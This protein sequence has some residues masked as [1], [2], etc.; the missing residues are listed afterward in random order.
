MIASDLISH[1]IFPLKKNDSVE[2][3]LILM[4][5]WKVFSLPVVEAG[6]VIGFCDVQELLKFPKKD[7]IIHHMSHNQ[8]VINSLN[9]HLFDIIRLFADNSLTTLTIIENEQFSGIVSWMELLDVYKRSYLSQQGAIIK[10]QM[11]SRSYS[12]SEISRLI[13]SNDVKILHLF[14]IPMNDDEGH[15]ELSIKLNTT[16][17]RN[18]L[19]TL[20][21]YQY[22]ITGIYNAA[23][24]DDSSRIK[25]E[26]LIKYLNI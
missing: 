3:A 5:D 7:K 14:I 6:K 13:E 15:V 24:L 17:I 20:E 26:N 23:E 21:R 12:L 18:V 11:P 22:S 2:G 16:D 1:R 4:Q 8:I 19:S 25:F 9:V 10:L